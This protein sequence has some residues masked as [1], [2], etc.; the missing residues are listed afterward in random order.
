MNL[1]I[2]HTIWKIDITSL[3]KFCVIFKKKVC[4][5]FSTNSIFFCFIL[6]TN[7][8]G[9]LHTHLR[10][11]HTFWNNRMRYDRFEKNKLSPFFNQLD[12]FFL[13]Q[14]NEKIFTENCT[15]IWEFC[16]IFGKKVRRQKILASHFQLNIFLFWCEWENFS[17]RFWKKD[18]AI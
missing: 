10:I 7:L 5:P 6:M 14:L 9:T 8:C 13:F 11:L 16:T 3:R 17:Q 12:I 1:A 2:L 18:A 15:D 4:S